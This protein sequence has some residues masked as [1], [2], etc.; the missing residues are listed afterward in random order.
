MSDTDIEIWKRIPIYGHYLAS[1]HGRIMN[2]K[3]G[4]KKIRAQATTL[5]GYKSITIRG[6]TH[7]VHRLIMA[8]FHGESKL[9]V[10]HMDM[11]KTNNHITNLEY[12]TESENQRHRYR[13]ACDPAYV[14]T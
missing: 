13:S 14:D 11:D 12:C 5:A 9:Q 8:A 2:Y 7:H 10:N 6:K 4:E 3:H 1:S